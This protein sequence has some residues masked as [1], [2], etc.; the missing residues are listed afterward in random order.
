MVKVYVPG[1][2]V[3][4][5]VLPCEASVIAI[6]KPQ[7]EN[8]HTISTSILLTP[9]PTA[10]QFQRSLLPLVTAPPAVNA[11][12]SVSELLPATLTAVQLWAEENAPL[13]VEIC[14]LPVVVVEPAVW[15][16][17]DCE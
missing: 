3:L 16:R 10:D 6:L 11:E 12:S 5:P 13:P 17:T 15:H 7:P 1:G 14:P 2:P 8:P 9:V 4:P